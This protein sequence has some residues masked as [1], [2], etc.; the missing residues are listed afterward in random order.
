MYG[1]YVQVMERDENKFKRSS[2]GAN[3]NQIIG[4]RDCADLIKII[5]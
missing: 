4:I 3:G 2:V 5:S 1:V